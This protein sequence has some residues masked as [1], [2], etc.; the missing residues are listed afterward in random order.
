[1]SATNGRPKGRKSI[2]GGAQRRTTITPF[3]G[4]GVGGRVV[5]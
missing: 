2:V 3:L 5:E 1:M 4:E